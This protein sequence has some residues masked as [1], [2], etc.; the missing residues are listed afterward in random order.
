MEFCEDTFIE[1]Y[2]ECDY[3]YMKDVFAMQEVCAEFAK[4]NV[5]L[6]DIIEV[7]VEA[8][9]DEDIPVETLESLAKKT[10]KI[11]EEQLSWINFEKNSYEMFVKG[12]EY[13]MKVNETENVH[14]DFV[15]KLKEEL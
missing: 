14:S 13:S 7:L 11:Y 4:R 1:V 5:I 6:A 9:E 12:M 10:R 8:I 15:S 2:G 3:K